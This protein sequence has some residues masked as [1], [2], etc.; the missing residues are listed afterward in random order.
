MHT[1]A[2]DEADRLLEER[3]DGKD[4]DLDVDDRL[5]STSFTPNG[6]LRQREIQR[7]SS[8]SFV[9]RQ[10]TDWTY[11]ATGALRTVS[12]VNKDGTT[13]ESHDLG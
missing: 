12:T 13:V 3:D 6:W 9:M 4:G 2:Y 5:V 7:K 8:G 11:F 1:F 10:R